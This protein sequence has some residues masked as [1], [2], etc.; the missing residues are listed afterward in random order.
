MLWC[1]V[2]TVLCKFWALALPEVW[3]ARLVSHAGA[4]C[5]QLIVSFAVQTLFNFT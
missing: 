3:L 1:L 4:V 5:V 2:S